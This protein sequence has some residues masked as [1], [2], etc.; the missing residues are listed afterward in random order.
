MS[1]WEHVAEKN[2]LPHGQEVKE[3]E[4]GHVSTASFNDTTW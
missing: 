3:R 2:G 4:K 1:W